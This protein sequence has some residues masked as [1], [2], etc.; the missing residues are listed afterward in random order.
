MIVGKPTQ[1]SEQLRRSVD[2]RSIRPRHKL[3]TVSILVLTQ[4]ILDLSK[5]LLGFFLRAIRHDLARIHDRPREHSSQ[6]RI[7]DRTNRFAG[8]IGTRIQ[9]IVL[10]N[11]R[12]SATKRLDASEHASLVKMLGP[13]RKSVV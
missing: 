1:I 8:A 7:L 12:H 2:R 3:Q 10:A 4:K 5:A 9:K 13:E 11:G 6:A